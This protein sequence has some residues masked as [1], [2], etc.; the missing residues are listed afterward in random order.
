MFLIL[1]FSIKEQII[2]SVFELG[3]FSVM[4]KRLFLD[5]TNSFLVFL[6]VKSNIE[7]SFLFVCIGGRRIISFVFVIVLC[8]VGL[9]I[10]IDS[11]VSS[12]NST[13]MGCFDV[14]GKRSTM[15]PR[16]EYVLGQIVFS[17]LL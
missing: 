1:F 2:F 3:L 4:E 16:T 11:I 10:R 9:N 5:F 12:K 14:M 6:S 7:I 13:L 15:Q 17:F 8:E